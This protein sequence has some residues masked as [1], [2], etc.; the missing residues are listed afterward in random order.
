MVRRATAGTVGKAGIGSPKRII[1]TG[2]F[3]DPTPAPTPAPPAAVCSFEQ[4][5]FGGP[6]AMWHNEASHGLTKDTFDWTR[7]SGSTS[8]PGT[9]PSKAFDGI[10][11]MYVQSQGRHSGEHATLRTGVITIPKPTMLRFRYHMR[12]GDGFLGVWVGNKRMWFRVGDKGDSWHTATVDLSRLAS[13]LPT[14]IFIVG[15]PVR[16]TPCDIAI[17]KIELDPPPNLVR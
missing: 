14:S 6:C 4:P 16:T 13:P 3:V 10:H 5:N 9:G 2:P 7:G 11:Y 17:D 12:G 8:T 1:Y 15:L